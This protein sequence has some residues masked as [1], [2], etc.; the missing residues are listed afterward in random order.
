[1]KNRIKLLFFTVIL[2]LTH[3]LYADVINSY[4]ER[5]GSGTVKD[6]NCQNYT[7]TAGALLDVSGG[8]TL[9][10]VTTFTNNGTW[11]YSTGRIIELGAWVNNGTVVAK[12]T[13]TGAI[14]NLQFTTLCGPISVLGTSDTDGDGISDADEGDNA[15]ALGHGITLDQDGDGI[16]NFLDDDSDGDGTPDSVEGGNNKDTNGNGIPDYLDKV[17]VTPPTTADDTQVNQTAGDAVTVDI[18]A[19]D[20]SANPMDATTVSLDPASV[21]G[22]IGTD[23]DSDGDIDKVVVPNEG[24]WTVNPVSG[25]VT[26]TPEAGFTE[27][28]TPIEYTVKDNTGLVSAPA[29]ITIDYINAL[30]AAD[31]TVTASAGATVTI[32]VLANDSGD[33]P[34]DPATVLIID[35]S[36]GVGDTMLLVAGQGTWSVDAVT[37]EITFTPEVG[38]FVDPTPIEYTVEDTEGT[39]SNKATVTID[40]P[41]IVTPTP[42]PIPTVTLTPTPSPTVLP[43]P[44]ATLM[45]VPEQEE[46]IVHANNDTN[47]K[48]TKHRATVL[49]VLK[50]D[51]CM[52]SCGTL[53]FTQSRKGIVSVDDAGTSSSILDDKIIYIPEENLY[54]ATDSFDYTIDDCNGHS[55][56]ATVT[57]N[58]VCTST[59]TSDAGALNK[60]SMIIL[61]MLTMLGSF[62]YIRREE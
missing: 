40:Y 55:S 50:N 42:T 4:I 3:P 32:P 48:I 18:L 47:I 14:P 59:Q 20:S 25:E 21:S 5:L 62:V 54:N 10:E 39:V 15:V 26:F 43:T 28:T 12:P 6:I 29:T 17:A 61:A 33:N 49:E 34:L 24:T 19:N 1:M 7:I 56:T 9:R 35:P 11:D 53:S 30:H 31:D 13:Q 23:T 45:P 8:G 38:F 51:A 60:V 37:G 2:M 16:Y 27:D 58:I 52:K 46:C 41:G 57:L 22:G 36:N 44:L